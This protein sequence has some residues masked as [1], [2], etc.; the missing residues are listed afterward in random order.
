[1]T[2][3]VIFSPEA[4]A[5]LLEL[6]DYIADR[7]GPNV[8]IGYI[9]RIEAYCRN[10]ER[11]PERGAKRDDIRLGLRTIGFERRVTIAFHI[12]PDAV[13]ID[14]MFYGGRDIEAALH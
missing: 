1:M 13:V 3:G 11:F 14:G 2:F 5:Q 6:Y 8:A 4:Q 12:E 9:S 7:A 10:F